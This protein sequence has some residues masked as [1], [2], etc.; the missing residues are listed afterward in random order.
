MKKKIDNFS[1]KKSVMKNAIVCVKKGQKNKYASKCSNLEINAK[2]AKN[3]QK[4]PMAWSSPNL[5]FKG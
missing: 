5:A 2:T 3:C 4:E 1:P